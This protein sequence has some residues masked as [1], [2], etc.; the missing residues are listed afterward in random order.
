MTHFG[1]SRQT[2]NLIDRGT[3]YCWVPGMESIWVEH[4]SM[5]DF[6]DGLVALVDEEYSTMDQLNVAVEQFVLRQG[7]LCRAVH[8]IEGMRSSNP[9]KLLL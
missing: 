9:N 2:G 1:G 4:T 3:N 6:V 8:K 7:V 5:S